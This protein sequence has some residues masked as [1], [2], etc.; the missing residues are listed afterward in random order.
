MS[1]WG[2][3]FISVDFDYNPEDL[4][5]TYLS[6]TYRVSLN[7]QVHWAEIFQFCSLLRT[8]HLAE[9]YLLA[10]PLGWDRAVTKQ[11]N[12]SVLVGLPF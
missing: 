11:D 3:I 9:H 12:V 10:T 5:S 7:F 6:N 4:F 1:L 8:Q 2:K